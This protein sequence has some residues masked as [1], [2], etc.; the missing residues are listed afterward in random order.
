[1]R[2][3]YMSKIIMVDVFK[4]GFSRYKKYHGQVFRLFGMIA[5]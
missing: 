1:M 4:D 2:C 3:I 5:R